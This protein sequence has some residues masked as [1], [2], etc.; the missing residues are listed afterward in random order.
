MV[1]VHADE[2]IGTQVGER[3]GA[4]DYDPTQSFAG[5]KYFFTGTARGTLGGNITRYSPIG[6]TTNKHGDGEENN[7]LN[8]VCRHS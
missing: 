4:S 6:K 8:N 1:A 5:K 7:N 2:L 3:D